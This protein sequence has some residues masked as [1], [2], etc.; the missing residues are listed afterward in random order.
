MIYRNDYGE[1]K[2]HSTDLTTNNSLTFPGTVIISNNSAYYSPGGEN[3]D[4]NVSFSPA[5]I[6]L[7]DTGL[8]DP[9]ILR[10]GVLCTD[11]NLLTSTGTTHIFNVTGFSN[12]TLMG[13]SELTSCGNF[14]FAAQLD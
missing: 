2:W 13:S 4:D 10:D 12:Y 5:N 3:I 8:T 1:I 14:L 9:T 7:I 6:T 11:C